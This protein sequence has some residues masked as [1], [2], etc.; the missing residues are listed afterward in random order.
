MWRRGG[1]TAG[2]AGAAVS[3]RIPNRRFERP[4][5][6]VAVVFGG[7]ALLAAVAWGPWRAGAAAAVAGLA[8]GWGAGGGGWAGEWGGVR[9]GVVVGGGGGGAGWR[10]RPALWIGAALREAGAARITVEG[11]VAAEPRVEAWR[12][13]AVCRRFHVETA[14]LRVG[15]REQ[16]VR[17]ALRVAWYG[18]AGRGPA[19]GEVWRFTGRWR[20]GRGGG[21]LGTGAGS[22]ERLETDWRGGC[23]AWG[24]RRRL[25]LARQLAGEGE[26]TPAEAVLQAML[27]GVRSELPPAVRRVFRRTGTLHLFAISG[28][29]VGIL[30]TLWVW[31]L[32]AAGL[33]R[34]SW[35]WWTAPVLA[36]YM[37]VTGAKASAV[38]AC[39]MACLYL[40][41]DACRRRRDAPSALAAAGLAILV[42]DPSQVTEPGF[43]LSFVIVGGLLAF[44][45]ALAGLAVRVTAPDRWRATPP[46][47]VERLARGVARAAVLST[48]VSLLAWLLALPLGARYFG[49]VSVVAVL[50]NLVVVPAAFPVVLAGVLALAG[51]CL[52]PWAGRALAAAAAAAT[53]GLLWILE[54]AAAPRWAALEVA[55]PSWVLVAAWY[56]VLAAAAQAARRRWGAGKTQLDSD[57]PDVARC[58]SGRDDYE[59][60]DAD[61]W[62]G[63]AGGGGADGAGGGALRV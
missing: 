56:G 28:L 6:P 61:G 18:G 9:L 50:A 25:A 32:R 48:G 19:P 15:P 44:A 16:R 42:W 62:M 49:L 22:A 53:G 63:R 17:G 52:W 30:A 20:P 55:R 40:G 4:L 39:V 23:T 43:V 27:L 60:D 36:G 11:T 26:P 31:A 14:R 2:R 51:G 10:G 57:D 13:A 58:W 47:R 37:L 38:R 33:S 34:P 41:A 29:H 24:I 35:F 8:G 54:Q 7:G 46:G 59:E 1:G 12:G 45:P 5:V 3:I 21:V